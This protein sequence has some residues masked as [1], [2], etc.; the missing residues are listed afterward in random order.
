MALEVE[1]KILLRLAA[2]QVNR[3]RDTASAYGAIERVFGEGLAKWAFADLAPTGQE[4]GHRVVSQ[5]ERVLDEWDP[6]P[7]DWIRV[8]SG[9][10]G[11]GKTAAAARYVA[12]RGGMLLPAAEADTWGYSGGDGLARAK[13]AKVLLVDDYGDEKFPTGSRWLATVLSSRRDQTTVVTTTLS[14]EQLLARGDHLASRLQSG[15]VVIEETLDRR[16]DK[17]PPFVRGLSRHM[18]IHQLAKTVDLISRSIEVE[19]A[20]GSIAALAKL[21]RVDL[22]SSEFREAVA[23]REREV[24]SIMEMVEEFQGRMLAQANEQAE[25]RRATT[26]RCDA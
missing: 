10:T 8:L 21:V 15:F 24:D 18:Q 1:A 6:S 22:G 14:P 3:A 11:V 13:T 16:T 7:F 12:E 17:T 4:K 2:T 5:A 26:G 23:A 9:P 20:A 25:L 19:D